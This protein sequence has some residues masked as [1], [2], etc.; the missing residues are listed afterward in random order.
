V[1][2]YKVDRINHNNL[3]LFN[4]LTFNRGINISPQAIMVVLFQFNL[5]IIISSPITVSLERIDY[6]FGNKIVF[7]KTSI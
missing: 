7:R 5:F 3:L 6:F 2:Y 4:K 1:D